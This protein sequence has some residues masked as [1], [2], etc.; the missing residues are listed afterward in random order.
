[1]TFFCLVDSLFVPIWKFVVNVMDV[2]EPDAEEVA[3]DTFLKVHSGTG[4]SEDG[5]R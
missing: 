3:Q 4:T 2:P 5:L 1:M